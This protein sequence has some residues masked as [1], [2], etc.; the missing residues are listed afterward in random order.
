MP[1]SKRVQGFARISLYGIVIFL[2]SIYLIQHFVYPGATSAPA[3][4]HQQPQAAEDPEFSNR[5]NA[6]KKMFQNNQYVDALNLYREAQETVPQL[7]DK[8]YETLKQGHLEIAHA[9]EAAG[10]ASSSSKV[11]V[12]LASCAMQEAKKLLQT[13]HW[14]EALTRAQDGEQ[15][16]RQVTDNQQLIVYRA[17]DLVVNV[18]RDRND[19]RDALQKQQKLIDYLEGSGE[20]G[21]SLAEAYGNLG[22]INIDAKQWD[23]AEQ[24]LTRAAEI[25]DLPENRQHSATA[26]FDRN[27]EDYLLLFVYLHAGKND[28]GLSKAEEYYTKYQASDGAFVYRYKAASFALLGLALAKQSNNQEAIDVWEKRVHE[29]P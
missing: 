11:Y 29:T 3:L 25:S 26:D 10:D 23:N 19:I 27:F 8:E 15:F 1:V 17:M 28:L 2:A 6:A 18:Y 4:S 5:I 22:G 7:D 9:Y 20:Q 16:A 12:A 24:A 14:D 21:D 13:R